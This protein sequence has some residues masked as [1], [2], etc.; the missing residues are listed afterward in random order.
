MSKRNIIGKCNDKSHDKSIGI[1]LVK[2]PSRYMRKKYGWEK[3]EKIM[4]NRHLKG[5]GYAVSVAI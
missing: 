3:A 2:N 5:L 1:L 4:F